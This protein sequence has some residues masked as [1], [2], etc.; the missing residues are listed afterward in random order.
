MKT[1]E[2][3]A[4]SA[5]ERIA[6]QKEFQQRQKKRVMKITASAVSICL[7]ILLGVGIWNSKTGL[8]EQD[9]QNNILA[10]NSQTTER[11]SY[12]DKTDL[13]EQFAVYTDSVV[14]PDT[15][16][17]VEAD[18][19]GCLYY[20]GHM[21]TQANSWFGQAKEL[22]HLVGECIG[23]AKGN[24][25][26]WSTQDEQATEFAST[27][28]GPVYTV[29]G[30]SEDF[31][32]CVYLE[33]TEGTDL[34]FL[35]NYDHIGLNTGA[36]IFEERLHVRNNIQK[37]TYLRH[38]DWDDGYPSTYK[39]LIGVTDEQWDEFINMLCSSPVER[40]DYNNNTDFY[41]TK[42]PKTQGHLYLDMKDGTQIELRLI[43]GGMWVYKIF[44]GFL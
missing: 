16:E 44:R 27:Y 14:L 33:N 2:E 41:G 24:L 35:D 32:L 36:D 26:E 11:N 20:K 30:Y 5:L 29:K 18:M 23:N 31:R 9:S 39:E 3:K 25:D 4:H 38:S 43:A 37:V 10:G 28:S 8:P 40:I 17:D 7:V 13:K 19:I 12:D 15:G 42:T 1:Y 6:K 21:Y 22:E 34:V